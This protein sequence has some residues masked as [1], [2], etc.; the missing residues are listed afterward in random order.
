M[1]GTELARRL[2]ELRAD[3]CLILVTGYW[4]PILEEEAGVA[5]I[6]ELV[7]KPVDSRDLA[8]SLART[9]RNSSFA[10]AG[11][12]GAG[13]RQPMAQSERRGLSDRFAQPG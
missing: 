7:T 9:L 12:P 1:M 5:G 3:I 11:P 4:G 2:R 6:D 10:A 13:S 8:E